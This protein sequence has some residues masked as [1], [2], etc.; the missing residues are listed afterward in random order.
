MDTTLTQN[1]TGAW[2]TSSE[3]IITLIGILGTVLVVVLT[4]FLTYRYTRRT[5]LEAEWRVDKLKQYKELLRALS[6]VTSWRTNEEFERA[7]DGFIDTANTLSLVAPIAVLK[8]FEGLA[9]VLSATSAGDQ[10]G[11]SLEDLVHRLIYEI[12]KDL[13]ATHTGRRRSKKVAK[14]EEFQYRLLK[15]R[16]D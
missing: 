5:R 11:E 1:L 13:K 3:L 7:T 15:L 6:R 8:T 14:E 4:S 10:Q 12:R 16:S 9:N 2:M